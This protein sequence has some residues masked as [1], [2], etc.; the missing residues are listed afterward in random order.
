MSNDKRRFTRVQF[1]VQ[2]EMTVNGELYAI[3]HI[4]NLSIGGCL[5]PLNAEFTP[6]STCH[7]KILMDA[8]NSELS[9]LIDGE[10]VRCEQGAIAVKFTGI[11]PDGLFHLHG[12]VLYNSHDSQ[13]VE[14]EIKRH[15]GLL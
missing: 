9:I 14:D 11:D 5:L 3:D 15:P 12:I 13:L 7:L 8:T 1:G 4:L 2:A 6:G 10:I